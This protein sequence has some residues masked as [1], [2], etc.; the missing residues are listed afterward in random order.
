MCSM[1]LAYRQDM[2]QR[3][4]LC[5]TGGCQACQGE[6]SEGTSELCLRNF[7]RESGNGS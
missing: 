6:G 3:D 5:V 4:P 1:G 7:W 2:N